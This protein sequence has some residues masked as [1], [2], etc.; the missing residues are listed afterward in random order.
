MTTKLYRL[1]LFAAVLTTSLARHFGGGTINWKPVEGYKVEFV[2]KMGWT[3]GMG[4][5]CTETKIGQFV[6]GPISGDQT[7]WK[8]TQGCTGRPIISNAS[9]YCMGAN[10]LERWEQGQMSFNYTFSNPGP[11]VAAFEGRKWMALGHGKG[12]GPWRIATTIDLRTRSDTN[13]SNSSPVA[14]SQ[15]IYYMQYDCHHELQIPV[16]DPDGDEVLCQWAKGNECEAVCNGLRGARLIEENCT[17]I[18]DSTATLG[19]KDG[20]MYGVALTIHDY[21]QTAI[22]LGGQDRK[23][24]MDS[25]SSVPLQFLIRTPAF[26][27][28]CNERPRFVSST[29]QQ[30]S[31]L[32]AQ[33]GDTV[34]IRV[35]ADNSNDFTKKISSIDL[36]GPV[37]LHQSALMP[38]PGHTNTFFKALTWQTSSADIGEHIVCATAV[39]ERRSVML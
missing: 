18:F 19:Y 23:T 3:Y 25:L 16:L 14:L 13:T 35:V 21:P 11:F 10:Q 15:V 8:C 36:M 27:T 28:A 12:S 2:F 9:Y 5:G 31:K 6:N 39:N 33:A 22:T 26:P 24:P 7:A 32:T 29:P 30:G 37:D 20:E 4:P 38:D 1:T 17:I 34:S